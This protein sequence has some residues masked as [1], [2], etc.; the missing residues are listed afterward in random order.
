VTGINDAGQMVGGFNDASGRAHGWTSD[1]IGSFTTL[2]APGADFTDITGINDA[3]QIV[4]QF[5]VG[6]TPHTFLYAA[7][8][9]T[10]ID[11]PGATEIVRGI[12]DGGQVVGWIVSPIPE[13]GSMLL[14]GSGLVGAWAVSLRKRTSSGARSE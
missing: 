6:P 11:L 9:F 13:P 7:G 14:F 4:G 3:G 8:S 1:A 2:D 12:N 5:Y 10:T